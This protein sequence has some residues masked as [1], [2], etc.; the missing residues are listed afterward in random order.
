[1]LNPDHSVVPLVEG[2]TISN[3][4]AWTA[5]QSRF[6]YIDTPTRRIDAFDVDAETGALSGRRPV[7]EVTNGMPD[8]MAIDDEGCLWVA[9]WDGGRVDRY[10]PDGRLLET[11]SVP[12]GGNVSSAAFGGPSMS[13][14]FVTT[15]RTGL[16]EAELRHAPHAGDL[17]AFEAPVTGPPSNR[18][19]GFPAC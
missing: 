7:V 10:R 4:M 3:G 18:F 15:A 17:F 11:L 14:L 6:Y 16:N 13:T 19:R 8:G 1:M 9:I 2:V 5:D 12:A